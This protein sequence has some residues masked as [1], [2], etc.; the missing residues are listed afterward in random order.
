M[1]KIKSTALS[2]E[3]EEIINFEDEDDED[4]KKAGKDD[5]LSF[6]SNNDED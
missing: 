5:S 6:D 2:K 4:K 1:L 3:L